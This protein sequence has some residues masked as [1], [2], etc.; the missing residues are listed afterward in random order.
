MQRSRSG[1]DSSRS[2]RDPSLTDQAFR[3]LLAAYR[4][5]W[6][7]NSRLRACDV[8][9]GHFNGERLA[10]PDETPRPSDET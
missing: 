4:R 2:S 9:A 7:D 6:I 3:A 5:G 1:Y 10:V 8:E